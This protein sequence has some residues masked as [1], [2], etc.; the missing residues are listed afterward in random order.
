MQNVSDVD[1][2]RTLFTEYAN[3]LWV[4]LAKGFQKNFAAAGPYAPPAGCAILAFVDLSLPDAWRFTD[5]Q[6]DV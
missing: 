6:A 1:V 5:R 3:A 4:D 2:L